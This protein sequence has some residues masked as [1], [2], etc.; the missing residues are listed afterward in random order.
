MDMTFRAF[1]KK[2]WLQAAAVLC[3]T[4][5]FLFW[6]ALRV[7][8]A[9][10]SKFLGADH[11]PSF[12]V[13]N[14]PL[15][16]CVL[17]GVILLL[18]ILSFV[19]IRDKKKWPYIASLVFSAVF[20]IAIGVVIANGSNDY[21][22][23]ILPKF[24]RSV[25]V[26]A[27][28]ILVFCLLFF[29]APNRGW[30]LAAKVLFLLALIAACT[31]VGYGLRPCRFTYRPVV[32]AVEDD[33][34]IVFSTSDTA[35]VWVEVGPEKYYDLYAGS[36]RSKDL[37]HK[38]TVPQRALDEAK[39]YK[40]CAR[41]MIYRGPF[42]GY[43]GETFSE[44]YSFIPVNAADGICYLALPDIHGA[45]EGAVS[46]ADHARQE[47]TLD[48]IVL[49]GD[50]TSMV[51]RYA[52]AQIANEIAFKITG[53]TIPVIYTR[54]NHE[55]KGEYAE[56]LY[57]YTGSKNGKFYYTFRL[58]DIYGI[59]LDLGEDHDDD[60]WEY[61]ETAQFDLYRE[62]QTR[63]LDDI[64]A[65]EEYKDAPYTI[66]VCHIPIPFVNARHNHEAV[67][68]AWTKRLN[69]IG[70]DIL[71]TGHQHDLYPFLE[72]TITPNTKLVYNKDFSGTEGKTYNGY[73]TDYHFN[74]FICGK[75][76]LTQHDEAPAG[77]H[78]DYVGMLVNVDLSGG[79]QSCVY[80]NSKGEIVPVVNPFAE[81]SYGTEPIVT[82]LK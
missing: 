63:M 67:K 8:W 33:Y 66:A 82:M 21:I 56:D 12:L 71:I 58:S 18:T 15:M 32:Y 41:Q 4:A 30:H 40:I 19:F 31:I 64:I 48:F 37:V 26:T 7:N 60:W 23:F 24:L 38:V 47:N 70:V 54:G 55:I 1:I 74:A 72:G 2:Y 76:G 44:Q 28:L 51:D 22:Q 42:G 65:A 14:L 43:T 73:M 69:E 25:G 35:I 46:L 20:A 68:A 13:M 27:A 62:E 39:S 34:Q 77:N 10:I 3:S 49:L 45:V 16:I 79:S 50:Q 5:V 9:G 57:K 36:M 6:I 78:T 75:R 17:M 59:M 61:Y 11:N 29:R 52:D 81:Y 53:S 80:M